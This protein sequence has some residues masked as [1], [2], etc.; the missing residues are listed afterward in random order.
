ME[1]A[2][3]APVA[4]GARGSCLWMAG[5]STHL[6]WSQGGKPGDEAALARAQLKPRRWLSSAAGDQTCKRGAALVPKCFTS[7]QHG[8]EPR[9]Q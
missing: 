2:R 3:R 7:T 9:S 6:L 5:G 1:S 8:S 4:V